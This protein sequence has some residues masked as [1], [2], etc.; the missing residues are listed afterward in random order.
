MA[1]TNDRPGTP[2]IGPLPF[3]R[4]D[5]DLFFGRVREVDDLVSLT[6]AH[7]A[8]LLYAESGAGKSSLINAGL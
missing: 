2:Y 8:V 1:T 7:R 4:E 5:A 3:G 6:F